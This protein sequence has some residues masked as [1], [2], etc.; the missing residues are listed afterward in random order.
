MREALKQELT[1]LLKFSRDFFAVVGV[2]A[3]VLFAIYF[4]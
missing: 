4:R 3:T 2:I 1:E